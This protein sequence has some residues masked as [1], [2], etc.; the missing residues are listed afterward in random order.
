MFCLV[1]FRW[2]SLQVSWFILR[3]K[4]KIYQPVL[5]TWSLILYCP[6]CVNHSV[7]RAL[8][9][10]SILRCLQASCICEM[11]P[12]VL[13]WWS[14]WVLRA[15]IHKMESEF[16]LSDI[17]HFKLLQKQT[18][19]FEGNDTGC[20]SKLN[21]YM[22]IKCIFFKSKIKLMDI[23]FLDEQVFTFVGDWFNSLR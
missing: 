17:S 19:V 18:F 13:Q 12:N 10:S 2:P 7:A 5:T 3:L 6:H 22:L 4:T 16:L 23:E 9:L 1:F 20:V 8:Y 15:C 14:P 11:F 21:P